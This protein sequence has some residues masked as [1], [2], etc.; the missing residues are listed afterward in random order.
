[1]SSK[2]M[3]A[4][5]LG[6]TGSVG[7]EVIKALASSAECD[8]IIMFNRREVDLAGFESPKVT[9]QVVDMA[10]LGE[11]QAM[12]TENDVN[13]VFV[14]MGVGAPS[15]LPRG[16]EG[17]EEL[18]RVDCVLPS[19]FL[20]SA[21]KANVRSA[22]LLTSVGANIKSKYSRMTGTAA[23]SGWYAHVKGEVETN[24]T[25]LRFPQ[26]ALFRPATLIGA[27]ATPG[28]FN[29]LAPKL[30][31][32]VPVNAHSIKIEH[33]AQK[34]ARC[35]QAGLAAADAEAAEPTTKIFQGKDLQDY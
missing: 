8:R 16:E 4:A 9:Q 24:A 33:L 2:Q 20:A 22:V 19:Q 32:A 21:Q 11:L 7:K 3:V 27:S 12:L 18:H 31:W 1:M 35:G 29:W 5:I 28:W 15:K 26:L 34:M 17:K 6:G 30:D 10:K 23:G 25:A 13:T 14:T